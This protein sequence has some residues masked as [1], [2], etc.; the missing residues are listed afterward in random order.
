MELRDGRI[1]TMLAKLYLCACM[2]VCLYRAAFNNF[3]STSYS[4]QPL[5]L[6]RE[7]LPN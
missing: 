1:D 7:L 6:A 4:T 2:P 3:T 5:I